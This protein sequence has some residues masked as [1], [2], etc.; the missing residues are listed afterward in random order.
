MPHPARFPH[1]PED[2]NLTRTENKDLALLRADAT[3]ELIAIV[4][5]RRFLGE[6]RHPAAKQ[7][8]E[9]AINN[10]IGHFLELSRAVAHLDPVQ[11]QEFCFHDLEWLTAETLPP[12]AP[13]AR[14]SGIA[15]RGTGSGETPPLLADGALPNHQHDIASAA[16]DL[17]R[18][19]MAIEMELSAI[20]GYQ[21]HVVRAE[22]ESTKRLLTGIMNSEKE[23]VAHFL[24]VMIEVAHQRH[25]LG[26]ER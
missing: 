3:G 17:D 12:P 8:L 10:E 25:H 13:L 5:Y 9:H 11:A 23:H 1:H 16:D 22:E 4:T 7:A 14:M 19:N 18:L 15:P 24:Q 2:T 6:A 21:E 26:H 20:N